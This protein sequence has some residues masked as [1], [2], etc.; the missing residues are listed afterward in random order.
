MRK[1]TI[2]CAKNLNNRQFTKEDMQMA[3]KHM[4]IGLTSLVIKE[5]QIKT[6]RGYHYIHAQMTKIA[7]LDQ[8]PR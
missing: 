7:R 8:N 6:I 3:N 1:Q 2:K 4:E 5:L